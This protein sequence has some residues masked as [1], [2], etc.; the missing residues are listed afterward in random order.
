MLRWYVF[1]CIHEHKPITLRD[2]CNGIC[3]NVGMHASLKSCVVVDIVLHIHTATHDSHM[4]A[5]VVI[6]L[7]HT[8][9]ETIY[10]F[11]LL[12]A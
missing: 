10:D 8:D 12:I 1:D 3:Y 6:P 2:I 5:I 9:T 11:T 7:T 4:V